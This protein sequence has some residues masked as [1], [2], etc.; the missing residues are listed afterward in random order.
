ML[1]IKIM[2]T[3]HANLMAVV[4]SWKLFEFRYSPEFNCWL[5]WTEA[6]ARAKERAGR[7]FP[8]EYFNDLCRSVLFIQYDRPLWETENPKVISGRS[9]VK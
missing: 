3:D 9:Y 5:F 7:A 2:K 4:D 6:G 1:S 8:W